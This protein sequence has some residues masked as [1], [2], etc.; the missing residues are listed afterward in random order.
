MRDDE[1][2]DQ[3]RKL[4]KDMTSA[5]VLLW[6]KIRR[7]ALGYKFHRQKPIGPFIADFACIEAR[8]VV[9]VDGATHGSQEARAYDASRTRFLESD[10]WRIVRFHNHE[11][12]Q[13]L[14]GVLETISRAAWENE[15][16]SLT[17]PAAAI[18]SPVEPCVP[19]N[20]S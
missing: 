8:L 19:R 16:R 15:S 18:R 2:I 6:S 3:A 9:E 1:K 5:E 10:D 14:T 17:E 12:F 20:G 4:R 11:V 7:E 13:N